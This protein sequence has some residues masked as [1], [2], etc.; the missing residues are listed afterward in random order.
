M[1]DVVLH[2]ADGAEADALLK[3]VRALGFAD[4][5]FFPY[6]AMLPEAGYSDLAQRWGKR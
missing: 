3:R 6:L 5:V 2:Q 1:A 4:E